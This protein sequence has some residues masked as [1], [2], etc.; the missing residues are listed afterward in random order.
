MKIDKQQLDDMLILAPHGRIDTTNADEFKEELFNALE[1][2]SNLMIDLKET[3][4]ISSSGLRVFLSAKKK[5][6]DKG[7]F[8]IIN[9]NANILEIF[10]MT[11]FTEMFQVVENDGAVSNDIKV[12]FFDIDGTLLSHSTGKVPQST[13]DAIRKLQE[14]GIKVVVATGRDIVE[15]KKLPLDEIDFDGYLTLNG[16]I[17]LDKDQKMFAGNEIDPGEVE[18]LVSIF[19]AGKLPFVLIAEN[20]R[21]INYVDD[22]VIRTQMDTHGTIPDIGEYNGE[23]IYQCLAFVDSEVRKKLDN[24]LDNCNITSWNETGIDIIAKTGGKAAGIQKFLD[25]EGINRS[26]TMAFGD[27]ENDKTMIKFAGTGV[28]MGNAVN[29]LKRE[30]DYVTADIDDDGIAKALIHFGL[31]EE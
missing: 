18:I 26:Q 20:K 25:K 30:A 10:E 5:L 14:K 21:Y 23:K 15:M 3:D 27:G 22:V 4:Y 31:I 19:E 16:N 9:A 29:E 2:S 8:S 12:I 13:I 11:G 28:A 17:C 1:N 7:A 6:S 24:L